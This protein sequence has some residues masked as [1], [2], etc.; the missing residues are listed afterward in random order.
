MTA[1]IGI[2]AQSDLSGDVVL[3]RWE[4]DDQI[5]FVAFEVSTLRFRPA[6]ASGLVTGDLM[7]DGVA[8]EESGTADGVS[9]R[10]FRMVVVAILRGYRRGGTA[11]ATAHAYYF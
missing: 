7:Y 4:A 9:R 1:S 3:Y 5:G 10:L 2:W 8:G 11:P 6:D